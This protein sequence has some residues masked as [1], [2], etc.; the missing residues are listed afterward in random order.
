[1]EKPHKRTF[2]EDN[3]NARRPARNAM[4]P[5]GRQWIDDRDCQAVARALL[6]DFITTGPKVAQFE[7]AIAN[8]VGARFAVAFSSGTSALRGACQAAGIENDDE[9]ITTPFTFVATANAVLHTGGTPVFADIDADTFNIDPDCIKRLVTPRTKA[10]LPVDYAGRPVAH[11]EI[12]EIAKRHE[13]IVIEDA[14]H[15]LGATYDGK[16]IGNIADMTMFS[17]HPVKPITTGEGG[18]I[19]TNDEELYERLTR[20]RS[21]GITRLPE[22]CD[23]YDGPWYYEM[24]S[25]GINARLTDFQAALGLSQMAK[26]DG[27]LSRRRAIAKAYQLAFSNMDTLMTPPDDDIARSGW[28]LYVIRLVPE[29][30]RADRAQIYD[31]LRAENIGV[32]V[33]YI[34]VY[35]HPFY[36]KL[37]Y[38][39]GLCPVSETCYNTVLSLPL[40]PSMTDD[41]VQDVI[42][43]VHKVFDHYKT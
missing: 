16:H 24:H 33:H 40:F 39:R 26:L 18:I 32:N 9:V 22:A 31:A 7:Q 14:A 27:F 38:P 43:A 42:F 3:E 17:F 34:P 29:R 21:H 4:L 28:H 37:G 36:Q 11:R 19:T 6:D 20:F 35:T 25:L 1:M 5:Y 15:A 2:E 23:H 12:A 13:L 10:I 41:D 30:L 8:Y